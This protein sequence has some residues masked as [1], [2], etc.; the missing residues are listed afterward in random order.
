MDPVERVL[1]WSGMRVPLLLR[2]IR[3]S[4]ALATLAAVGGCGSTAAA[5][6]AGG[7]AGNDVDGEIGAVATDDVEQR[8]HPISGADL[9][10]TSLP[11]VARP[12]AVTSTLYTRSDD[13]F[14]GPVA[15][16]PAVAAELSALL[17][18]ESVL[19]AGGPPSACKTFYG[20]GLDFAGAAPGEH[21]E[22]RI[23]LVCAAV[24]AG[25]G[26]RPLGSADLVGVDER[27]AGLAAQI[28]P[29]EPTLDGN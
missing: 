12:T 5:H 28:W 2:S 22:V 14:R 24:R 7:G 20:F 17:T 4:I 25:R 16:P 8:A 1:R 26:D 11:I 15:V 29:D 18:D 13:V 6:R 23:C 3:V 27:L 19:Q 21:V 9:Y 10:G